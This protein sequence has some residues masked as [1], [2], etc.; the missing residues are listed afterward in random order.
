MFDHKITGNMLGKKVCGIGRTRDLGQRKVASLESVLHPQVGD[1][2][3]P[4]SAQ[5]TS[6]TNADS[7]RCVGENV[8][9]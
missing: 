3:M 8:N 4:Y 2:Q 7:G 6:A 9:I 1:V 5:A